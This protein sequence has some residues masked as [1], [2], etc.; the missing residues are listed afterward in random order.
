MN[1]VTT[2]MFRDLPVARLFAALEGTNPKSLAAA[3]TL[4]WVLSDTEPRPE[5]ARDAVD[6]DT[7][8]CC[9]TSAKVLTGHSG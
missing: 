4:S 3:A 2:A 6:F 1:G 8:A 9:A 5:S 7:P